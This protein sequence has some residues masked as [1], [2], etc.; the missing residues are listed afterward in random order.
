MVD[1]KASTGPNNE[2]EKEG[3]TGGVDARRDEET[4][5]ACTVI[6]LPRAAVWI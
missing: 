6:G 1:G 5:H 3:H 4:L 2:Y